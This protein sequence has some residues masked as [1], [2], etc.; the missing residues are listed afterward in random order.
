MERR[1]RA[2][3]KDDTVFKQLFGVKK[4]TFHE[5]LA[6]LTAAY[7]VRRRKGGPRPKLTTG[8][9]LF[10]TLQYLVGVSHIKVSQNQ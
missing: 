5:M 6:V 7:E 1:Q 10:M 3:T 4:E 8:D 9:Q 2:F